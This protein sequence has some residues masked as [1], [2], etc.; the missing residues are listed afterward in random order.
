[1]RVPVE[2]A[3]GSGGFVD[4]CSRKLIGFVGEWCSGRRSEIGDDPVLITYML[5]RLSISNTLEKI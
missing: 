3:V 5:V 1:M 2:K 4:R